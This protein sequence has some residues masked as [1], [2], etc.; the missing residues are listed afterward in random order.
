MNTSIRKINTVI[1]GFFALFQPMLQASASEA[2]LL[3]EPF[4]NDIVSDCDSQWADYCEDGWDSTGDDASLNMCRSGE[5]SSQDWGV[6]IFGAELVPSGIG[7]RVVVADDSGVEVSVR[8]FGIEG[9]GE[10]S[11]SLVF[12]DD[13]GETL[14]TE[15]FLSDFTSG[16]I[17]THLVKVAPPA[18]TAA[19]DIQLS[20]TGEDTI[21]VVSGVKVDEVDFYAMTKVECSSAADTAEDTLNDSC[22]NGDGTYE[23]TGTR[24]FFGGCSIDCIGLCVS[25]LEGEELMTQTCDG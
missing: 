16:D 20:T 23:C 4:G 13:S 22:E 10:L 12:L 8:A 24:G 21:L 14:G 17:M 6:G 1:I 19:I 3:T 2:N 5:G 7:Q 11:T 25:D 18:D 15:A 9:S